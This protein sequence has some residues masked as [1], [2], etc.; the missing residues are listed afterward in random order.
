MYELVV[1]R[2]YD[3][4]K[5]FFGLCESCYWTASVLLKVENQKCPIC[6][7]NEVA[8]IPIGSNEEYEYKLEPQGGLQI[9]FSLVGNVAN[10]K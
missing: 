7:C 1:E 2:K 10:K 3:P 9:K 8:L 4:E 5:R 6:L